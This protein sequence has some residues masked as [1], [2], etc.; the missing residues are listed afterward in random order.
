MKRMS[1]IITMAICLLS[2]GLFSHKPKG[3]LTYCSYRSNGAAG[4]GTDYCQLI[5][6]ADSLPR[7]VVV[8]NENNRFGDPVTRRSYS[9]DKSVVDSLAKILMDVKVYKLNGYNVNEPICGGHS[10]NLD[11]AYASGDKVSAYWYGN[12]IKKEAWSA[13]RMI[14]NFFAPWRKMAAEDE[15]N[16]NKE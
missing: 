12:K 8:L 3:E 14:E 9:V 7:V 15:K 5:A 6:E 1:V 2:C 13:Y 10:H 11:I 4:L 16:S